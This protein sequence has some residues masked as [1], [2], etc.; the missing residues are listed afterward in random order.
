MRIVKNVSRIFRTFGLIKIIR[1]SDTL[2]TVLL[3][4]KRSL[5]EIFIYLIHLFIGALFF[6]TLLFYIENFDNTNPTP[7]FYSIPGAF[8][9]ALITMTTVGYGDVVPLT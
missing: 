9:W 2:N 6:G 5:R 7:G 4:F 8:Y 1:L 3:T